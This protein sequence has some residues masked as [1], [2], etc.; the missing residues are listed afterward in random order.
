MTASTGDSEKQKH[1]YVSFK[2]WVDDDKDPKVMYVSIPLGAMAENLAAGTAMVR[3]VLD[4]VKGV[5]IGIIQKRRL[6]AQIKNGKKLVVPPN[7][8]PMPR[9]MKSN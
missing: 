9:N 7:V 1:D 6:G 4:E 2:T 5:C 8:H 3:G